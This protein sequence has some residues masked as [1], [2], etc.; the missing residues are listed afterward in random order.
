MGVEFRDAEIAHEVA[1]R[2]QAAG[3]LDVTEFTSRQQLERTALKARSGFSIFTPVRDA[4]DDQ[5][6]A[7]I[8]ALMQNDPT[9][10]VGDGVWIRSS[11]APHGRWPRGV[12]RWSVDV[13]SCNL[14]NDTRRPPHDTPARRRQRIVDLFAR[15]FA[16]WAPALDGRLMFVHSDLEPHIR[17]S[18]VDPT[19]A[20]GFKKPTTLGNAAYPNDERRGVVRFRN[21][22]R[23]SDQGI[24]DL[25]VHELGHTLGLSHSNTRPSTM[26]PWVV[27][28]APPDADARKTI[29]DL[30]L[31]TDPTVFP[32][33]RASS[34]GPSLTA[35][36]SGGFQKRSPVVHMAWKGVEGTS[37]IWMSRSDDLGRSWNPQLPVDGVRSTH[38]P[39]L[40]GFTP[41]P[42]SADDLMMAWK[43][44][45]DDQR[46]FFATGFNGAGFDRI[47][48]LEG[49]TSTARPALASDGGTVLMA[50]KAATGDH[51]LHAE[52]HD[53]RWGPVGVVTDVLTDHA[54]ALTTAT[55]PNR[56]VLYA[57]ASGDNE[58]LLETTLG[59]TG[60]TR[61]TVA[62]FLIAEAGESSN[63]SL[64]PEEIRTSAHPVAC[65][66]GDDIVVA[67]KGQRGD[68][69]VWS[70][71][72]NGPFAG[73][74]HIAGA[75]SS[76]GPGIVGVDGTLIAAWKPKGDDQT[77]HFARR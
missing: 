28:A 10:S 17:I 62:T 64:S 46:L 29:G 59:S 2:A 4:T 7:D 55:T 42:G 77:L 1:L 16:F 48:Q 24:V 56:F 67:Y 27:T 13:T 21:D 38:G 26:S 60:W 12:L 76:T 68:E 18:F 63:W 3:L 58:F 9:C 31:W 19:D 74:V 54:P 51:V 45:G 15:A 35:S 61:P 69:A 43:G 36:R 22:R 20:N 14:V 6:I 66:D 39:A 49:H 47:G 50:W 34:D 30:Y 33:L 71:R 8:A 41:A 70:F 73:P 72:R 53:N 5:L 25:A 23:W 44:E 37:Q 40:V 57:Q 65:R 32:D 11:G 52:Y 75:L